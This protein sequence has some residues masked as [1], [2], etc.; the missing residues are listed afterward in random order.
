MLGGR[1]L[2]GQRKQHLAEISAIRQG[3]DSLAW[4]DGAFYL[5]KKKGQAGK[6]W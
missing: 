3:P 6:G 1:G 2:A 5:E 4:G